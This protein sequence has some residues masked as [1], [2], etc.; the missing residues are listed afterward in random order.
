MEVR[1]KH[2][3]I[4]SMTDLTDYFYFFYFFFPMNHKHF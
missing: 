2:L 4:I 1:P 3:K